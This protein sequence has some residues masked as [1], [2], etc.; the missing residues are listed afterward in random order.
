MLFKS[1]LSSSRNR[2]VAACCLLPLAAVLRS[3]PV[4]AVGLTSAQAAGLDLGAASGYTVVGEGS[5]S[6]FGVDGPFTGNVLL[7]NGNQIDNGTPSSNLYQTQGTLYGTLSYDST[8]TGFTSSLKST[9]TSLVPSSTSQAAISAANSVSQYASSLTPTQTIGDN[10]DVNSNTIIPGNR[11]LNVLNLTDVAGNY[12][13]T[14]KGT[15]SDYYVF[16]LPSD[17]HG[18]TSPP[19]LQ[20]NGV[21]PSHILFNLT[22][23]TF[24]TAFV[25]P[26]YPLYG[27][28]LATAPR[29]TIVEYVDTGRGTTMADFV[30][31]PNFVDLGSAALINVGADNETRI[32]E[33]PLAVPEP[34]N[35]ENIDGFFVSLVCLAGMSKRIMRLKRNLKQDVAVRPTAKG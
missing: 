15:S 30:K 29:T 1:F 31:N 34:K 32:Y 9:T 12:T 23:P 2:T 33:Y 17:S 7:G 27:T 4:M 6:R 16:N 18:D 3:V 5:G 26:G 8:V 20:F 21:D 35:I 10:L 24:F 22:E 11:G 25:G 13:L 28:Y 14:L 19:T